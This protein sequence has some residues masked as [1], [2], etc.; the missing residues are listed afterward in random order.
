M[1]L[2]RAYTGRRKLDHV[3]RSLSRLERGGLQSLSR[4]AGR[5]SAHRLRPGDPRHRGMTD[6]IADV[7]VVE[8]NNLDAL[9]SGAWPSTV[10][11]SPR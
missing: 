2:A 1:R 10:R 4:S 9:A 6:S 11:R 8:W 7:I 5:S 3:R